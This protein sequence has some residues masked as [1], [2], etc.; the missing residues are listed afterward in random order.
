VSQPFPAVE[1]VGACTLDGVQFTTDPERYAP[2]TWGKNATVFEGATTVTIQDFDFAPGKI[3]LA[4]AAASPL[5]TATM[6]GV[7]PSQI[8]GCGGEVFVELKNL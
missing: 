8:V 7:V 3:T 1:A 6:L 2:M 5:D 4:S